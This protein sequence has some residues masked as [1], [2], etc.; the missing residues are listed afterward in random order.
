MSVEKVM[1]KPL[2][3]K[4]E[5]DG[6]KINKILGRGMAGIVWDQGNFVL[7]VTSDKNEAKAMGLVKKH[8]HPNIVRVNKVFMYKSI[9]DVYMIEQEK[10]Q[11]AGSLILGFAAFKALDKF[12]RNDFTIEDVEYTIK[13]AKKKQRPETIEFVNQMIFAGNHMKNKLGIKS[14][15]DF[16]TG[17][18]MKKGNTYKIIDI[19]FTPSKGKI[20]DIREHIKRNVNVRFMQA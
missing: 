3:K 6:Y 20:D 8:P 16:H 19:G 2:V 9:P 11:D 5:S 7:K 10:L 1:T 18:Y 15:N 17:N 4:L 14:W 13:N 12:F